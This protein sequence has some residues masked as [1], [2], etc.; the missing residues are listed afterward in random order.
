MKRSIV[1]LGTDPTAERRGV[2]LSILNLEKGNKILYQKY[3]QN[4]DIE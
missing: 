4:D 1:V 2:E 3:L